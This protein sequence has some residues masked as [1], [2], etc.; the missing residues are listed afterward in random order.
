VTTENQLSLSSDEQKVSYGLG[1]QF[2]SEL[3]SSRIDG[4]D[5]D[6]V[7]TGLEQAFMGQPSVLPKDDLSAAYEAIETKISLSAK[8]S[9][10]KAAAE[11]REFLDK[12]GKR[13]GVVT[14]DSGLQ[15]EILQKGKG[16]LASQEAVVRTHY[17]GYMIDG[18]MF[19]SSVDRGQPA[20]FPVKG[21]IAGWTEALQMM[22]VGS[23]WRLY[24]PPELAY[25]NQGAGETIPPDSTLIFDVELLDIVS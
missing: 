17:T 25:G 22:P 4:L 19:D 11:G 6:A 20:E 24:I 9:A 8:D 18:T 23:T 2:G 12:N 5:L 15:Y 7:I 13:N 1:R 10:R 3:A 16:G 21:V 14:T